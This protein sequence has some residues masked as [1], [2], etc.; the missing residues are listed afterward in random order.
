LSKWIVLINEKEDD[1]E[2]K[3][4]VDCDLERRK[5]IPIPNVMRPI[6]AAAITPP[7]TTHLGLEYIKDEGGP[8]IEFPCRKKIMPKTAMIAPTPINGIPTLRALEIFLLLMKKYAITATAI[9]TPTMVV[10]IDILILQ[11]CDY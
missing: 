1:E 8:T 5:M 3:C 4:Q 10:L 7:F 11:V 6:P 2:G 9:A